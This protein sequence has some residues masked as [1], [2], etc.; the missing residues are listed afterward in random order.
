MESMAAPEVVAKGADYLALRIRKVAEE[1]KVP[2]VENRDLA[3]TLYRTV[4]I[5]DEVPLQLY[6]AVAQILAY[7]YKLKKNSYH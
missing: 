3:R 1:H 2:L 7:V 5:G 6:R 4:E